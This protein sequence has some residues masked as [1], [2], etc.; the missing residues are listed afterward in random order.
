MIHNRVVEP[1]PPP[2]P[3]MDSLWKLAFKPFGHVNFRKLLL[4]GCAHNFSVAFAD[5]FVVLFFLQNMQMSQLF[6]AFAASLMWVMRWV[7]AR[8]WGFLEDR[9]GP[10]GVLRVCASALV[11][12]PLGLVFFGPDYPRATLLG[13]HLYMGFFNVGFE[14]AFT[15]LLLG[16]TP[17]SNKSL[18]VSMFHGCVGLVAAVAP[19]LGGVFVQALRDPSLEVR[20]GAV[21]ALIEIGEPSSVP[22]LLAASRSPDL[23]DEACVAPCLSF[24][25]DTPHV[26]SRWH[27]A[28]ALARITVAPIDFYSVLQ[29]ELRV[30]GEVV[31]ATPNLVNRSPLARS[32]SRRLRKT[33]NTLTQKAQDSYMQGHYREATLGFVLATL[34]CMEIVPLKTS[35]EAMECLFPSPTSKCGPAVVVLQKPLQPLAQIL[36]QLSATRSRLLLSLRLAEALWHLE[37]TNTTSQTVSEE[38]ILA[39]CLLRKL[40]GYESAG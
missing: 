5:G 1:D 9:F 10:A 19:L 37:T 12:W 14:T 34:S 17:P 25:R 39:H 40:L 27:A 32:K 21:K 30:R 20:R 29:Q 24:M 18:Y 13:I 2:S 23:G 8:Y 4:F 38:P 11:I 22:G 28:L 33:A 26:F 31:A 6:I 35:E 3:V 15:A 36:Q 7:M 16:L